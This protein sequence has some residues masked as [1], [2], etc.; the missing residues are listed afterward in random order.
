MVSDFIKNNL[1]S[2]IL[3]SIIVN[4]AYLSYVVFNIPVQIPIILFPIFAG[5]YFHWFSSDLKEGFISSVF[6][7]ILVFIFMYLSL[8]TPMY[9][10]VFNDQG[11][12]DI[13]NFMILLSILRNII[14][15]SF[16]TFISYIVTFFIKGE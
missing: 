8:G 10:G 16:F 2:S 15:I 5:A 12:V 14:V 11:Y 7:I 9:L 6:F 3:W 13:F 1:I 4:C